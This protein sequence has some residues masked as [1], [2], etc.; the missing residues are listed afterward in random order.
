M[1][2]IK[3][4][5]ILKDKNIIYFSNLRLIISIKIEKTLV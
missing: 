3:N 4:V 1:K 2:V 5:L